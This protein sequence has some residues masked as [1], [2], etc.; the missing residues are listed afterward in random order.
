VVAT[1]GTES[2]VD[3]DGAEDTNGTTEAELALA[4]AGDG[5]AEGSRSA[6]SME[7][8]IGLSTLFISLAIVLTGCGF[9]IED[10]YTSMT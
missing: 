6:R 10:T 9:A 8:S 2:V 1:A 4:K 7:V 3:A 5:L